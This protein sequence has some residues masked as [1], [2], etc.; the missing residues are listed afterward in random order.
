MSTTPSFDPRAI[1]RIMV[2]ANNWIGDVVMISPALAALRRTYPEARIDAVVRPQ[3]A[4]CFADH[5]SVDGV[6]V[7]DPRRHRGLLGTL[8]FARELS[9]RD[10]DLAVLFQKAAG[11][12]LLARLAGIPRRV[13][14]ATDGRGMLLTDPIP[15]TP[16]ARAQHHVEYF[17]GVARGAGCDVGNGTRPRVVFPLDAQ[18]RAFA[19]TFL[20]ERG[21]ARFAWLAAFAPGASKPGRAWHADRFAALAAQL[22]CNHGAGIVVL[23]GPSDRPEAA[24]ILQEVGESGIDAVAATTVRGMAALIERCRVFVGN[25]SGPMHVA[26]ALDVPLLA[27]FG[28]G[29]PAKTAPWMAPE[30]FVALS[31]NFHCAPCRQDF[32]REC[33]PSP[34]LKPMCLETISTARAAAALESLLARTT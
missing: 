22:A 32:F 23:G 2:R 18:S 30:R 6:V 29:I 34:S 25:D 8:R 21:A 27:M 17:L 31:E 19:D 10:Y 20:S 14:Y 33:D 26:A 12:A 13:G 5:P 9:R 24:R 15:E 4:D 11:A 16:A 7:Q 1:R 3:V 28:P